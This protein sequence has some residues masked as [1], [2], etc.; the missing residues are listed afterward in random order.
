ML[1]RLPL[2]LRR[3]SFSLPSTSGMPK[4]ILLRLVGACVLIALL[5]YP[6]GMA[7]IHNIDDDIDLAGDV[8]PGQSQSVAVAA[9]LIERETDIHPWVANDPWF[10]PGAALDNMPNFQQGIVY[11]L[12]RFAIEMSDQIGR[13]R[14][15][16]EVDKD[17]D[18]A[19]GLLKYAGDVWVFDL[20]VSL[21]PT[22]PS[23]AQYRAARKS[24]LS[25]N[26]RLASGEA[27]FDRR[28]DNLETTLERIAADLGSGSAVI[29][30]YIS[31][32]SGSIIDIHA[33]D[34]YY[35]NKGRLYAYYLILNALKAD[36]NNVIADKDV[37]KAWD[38]MLSSLKIAASAQPLI[39]ING[40]PDSFWRPSHLTSQ[41]FYLLRARTQLKEVANILLK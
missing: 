39:V 12:S 15:S 36:F 40:D 10:L 34:I 25:Y 14:G 37:G 32:N 4:T 22:A 17:L 31:E 30:K 3:P 28:A 9:K 41:G 27:V 23:D 21:A 19:A 8:Q 35:R 24:L 18:K 16:S 2:W 6:L 20:S 5:Y 7:L 38:Q 1:E 11:A 29:D 13:T 33:D 26:E